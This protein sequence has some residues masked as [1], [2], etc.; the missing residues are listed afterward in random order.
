MDAAAEEEEVA[1][2]SISSWRVPRNALLRRGS[3]PSCREVRVSS[4]KS[5]A[6]L[7]A[8][9]RSCRALAEVESEK[10]ERGELAGEGLGGGDADFRAGVGVDGAVRLRG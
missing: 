10:I 4:V 6:D 3:A 5:L 2:A 7:L 1:G 9:V 8:R